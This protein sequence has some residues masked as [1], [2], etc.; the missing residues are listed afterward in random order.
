VPASGVWTPES[1]HFPALATWE[2]QTSYSA[3]RFQPFT[4]GDVAS[5]AAI[6]ALLPATGRAARS[7]SITDSPYGAAPARADATHAIQQALD[8]AAAMASQAAP[9]DVLVPAGTF[10]YSAALEVGADGDVVNHCAC[11][12]NWGRDGAA[13]GLSVVGGGF[14]LL[15]HNDIDRTQYARPA[16]RGRADERPQ[17]PVRLHVR[18]TQRPTRVT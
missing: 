6:M 12:A 16:T 8:A 2:N 7:I 4:P 5:A 9:V 10:R 18:S 14:V 13:R 3:L 11:I 1:D 17:A 15:D